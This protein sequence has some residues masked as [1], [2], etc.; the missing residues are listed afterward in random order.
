[1][2]VSSE[3]SGIFSHSR[4]RNAVVERGVEYLVDECRGR[5]GYGRD[6]D[7]LSSDARAALLGCAESASAVA[8]N[9]SID[10]VAAQTLLELIF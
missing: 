4:S 2:G 7:V 1:M 8:G 9:D 5:N 3:C 6:A 10:L